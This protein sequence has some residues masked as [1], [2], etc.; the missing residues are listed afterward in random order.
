MPKDN[1]KCLGKDRTGGDCRNGA[2]DDTLF[3]KYHQ[4]MNDYNDDMLDNLTQCKG[5]KK[6]Y[7]LPDGGI[8][9]KCRERGKKNREKDKKKVVNCKKEG[10]K[11]KVKENGYC[12]KHQMNYFIETVEAKGLKVCYN[13]N[14][15]CRR[16]LDADYGY[17]KCPDCLG[18]ERDK[19]KDKYVKV[20]KINDDNND[21][22]KLCSKCGKHNNTEF[23]RCLK[24]R[25]GQKKQDEK[26]KG[27]KRN[28]MEELRNNPERMAKKKQWYN[29]NYDRVV[30]YWVKYRGKRIKNEG[31]EYWKNNAKCQKKWVEENIDKMREKWEENKSNPNI[32]FS[33]YKY[34]AEKY[35]IPWEL[36]KLNA[37]ALMTDK[38]YYCGDIDVGKINGIDRK[39]N[40]DGYTIM[41]A[42]SCCTICNMIKGCLDIDV[43]LARCEHILA[44]LGKINGRMDYLLFP[45]GHPVSYYRYKYRANKKGLEF[46]LKEIDWCDFTLGDCY[47]C[48]KQASLTH[49]NGIDR[50][51]N[52]KG[53]FVPDYFTTNKTNCASCCSEC[54]YMKGTYSYEQL[55][56]K[57][58]MTYK[59][60][61]MDN[62]HYK[63]HKEKVYRKAKKLKKMRSAKTYEEAKE[64]ERLYKKEYR[65]KQR[66]KLGNEALR[67]KWRI[68][69]QKQRHGDNYLQHYS[70]KDRL[71]NGSNG[72]REKKTKEQIREEARMRKQKSR[73]AMIDKY[74]SET[75]RA[76]RAKEV[77]IARAK[78]QGN[79]DRANQLKAELDELRKTDD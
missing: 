74:G 65:E 40:T 77:A 48:G 75:W 62:E 20:K 66:A 37:V 18:K 19:Y 67:E 35:T 64:A 49:R 1:V 27:R 39:N 72:R 47:I 46:N 45:D 44:N 58:V 51:D 78:K 63:K 56:E 36:P 54:N 71:K 42:V 73:Q 15:G 60:R 24:C 9:D 59:N 55:V 22:N 21:Y 34:R 5:C 38:C 6:Q 70:H 25:E 43:Y 14:R 50:I 41:N 8:C 52:D 33:N 3:C 23:K 76:I 12:G 32:S 69:K 29:D 4:Y 57:L 28:W 31:D 13:V 61:I 30:S 53:Y 2:I 11:F 26:R 68:E 79:I 16:E 10:C 7:Y 17:S